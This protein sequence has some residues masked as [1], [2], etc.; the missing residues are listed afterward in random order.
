MAFPSPAPRAVL[1]F[2]SPRSDVALPGRLHPQDTLLAHQDLKST[3]ELENN[4]ICTESLDLRKLDALR[5]SGV[6]I[7]YLVRCQRRPA[8]APGQGPDQRLRR[9]GSPFASTIPCLQLAMDLVNTFKIE[10]GE[11]LRRSILALVSNGP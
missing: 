7:D 9:R 1:L 3:L 11:E 5:W 8:S 2:P 10:N 4:L 6:V